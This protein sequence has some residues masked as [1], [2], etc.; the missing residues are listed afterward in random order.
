MCVYVLEKE[1]R[2]EREGVKSERER[3]RERGIGESQN[4]REEK[5]KRGNKVRYYDVN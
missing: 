4:L 2:N 1:E 5:R 3:V